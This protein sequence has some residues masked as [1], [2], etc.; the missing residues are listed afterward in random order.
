LFVFLHGSIMVLDVNNPASPQKVIEIGNPGVPG[1]GWIGGLTVIDTLLYI[2]IGYR[3]LW[4]YNVANPY[5]PV[6]L[7]TCDTEDACGVAVSGDYAY[8]ADYDSG[9]VIIDISQPSAP[10]MVGS[11]YLGPAA[12]GVAV[13]DTFAYVAARKLHIV[14]IANPLS[15]SLIGTWNPHGDEDGM[16]VAVQGNFVYLANF[17][18]GFWIVDVTNPQSP[19]SA[20][21]ISY[22]LALDIAVNGNYAYGAA[23]DAGLVIINITDPNNAYIEGTL[24]TPAGFQGVDISGNYVYI[25]DFPFS[26]KMIDASDPANPFVIGE[27]QDFVSFAADVAVSGNYAYVAHRAD[28]LRIVD[29]SNPYFPGEVGFWD[30]P[31]MARGVAVLDSYAYVAD[32]ESGLRI[33]DITNP[34]SPYEVGYCDTI[35][36]VEHVTVSGDYAYLA[37]GNSGFLKIIDI[38][39][40]AIPLLVSSLL[41]TGGSRIVKH[42]KY[43]YAGRSIIDVSNPYAPFEIGRFPGVNGIAVS[44]NYLYTAYYSFC[45]FD[46]SDHSSP[47][48]LSSLDEIYGPDIALQ[49]N[50][51][52][53]GGNVDV[54][55]ITD[56][57]NPEMVGYYSTYINT[58]PSGYLEV[59]DYNIYVTCGDRG[60]HIFRFTGAPGIEEVR[61]KRQE[62]R[63]QIYPNPFSK[64]TKIS[65]GIGHSAKGIDLKIYDATGRMVKQWDYSAI[66]L[67]NQIIWD[68]TDDYG[69]KL[70]SGVYFCRLDI[71]KY[72]ET[73]KILFLK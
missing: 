19:V 4:I 5:A 27:Y 25:A 62:A 65:F 29:V 64:L 69:K 46:V 59:S 21:N 31:Y 53:V 24:D 33:I 60:L 72:N 66:R 13:L 61:S 10:V 50:Y 52:F 41:A 54:I 23:D 47:I 58:G 2:A 7:G 38:S 26:T 20:D 8:V 67:S 12:R 71:G 17:F 73:Q 40:P 63:L 1:G 37:C 34:F 28:G 56:P 39:N 11:L 22:G 48:L 36:W 43:V 70:P 49:D 32:G 30:T 16:Q 3:G 6:R 42:G 51:A 57:F 18:L 44:D 35:G 14:N 55:D 15:P 9:L 45:V 68:G